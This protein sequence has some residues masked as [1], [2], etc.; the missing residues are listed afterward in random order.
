MR[1]QQ[2]VTGRTTDDGV[3]R[4][5]RLGL[6]GNRLVADRARGELEAV[7]RHHICWDQLRES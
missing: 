7:P 1:R 2:R 3:E 5:G 6:G 4:A